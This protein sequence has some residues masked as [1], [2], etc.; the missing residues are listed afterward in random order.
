[1]PDFN[2]LTRM[3]F[4]EC[5]SFTSLQTD[6]HHVFPV[7]LDVL[8]YVHGGDNPSN[9]NSAV[10]LGSLIEGCANARAGELI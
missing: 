7:A 4:K 6:R 8:H 10:R 2:G 1:M 5:R 3:S 9:T